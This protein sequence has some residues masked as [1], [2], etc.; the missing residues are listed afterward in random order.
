MHLS[1]IFVVFSASGTSNG[2]KI[3]LEMC[4][5]TTFCMN[6]ATNWY[7]KPP[8]EFIMGNSTVIVHIFAQKYGR[9]FL[10]HCSFTQ[11]NLSIF[12]TFH[13]RPDVF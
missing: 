4:A 11:I 7:P 3:L 6:W 8:G 13:N 12:V 10:V 1:L 9:I 5:K 2:Y